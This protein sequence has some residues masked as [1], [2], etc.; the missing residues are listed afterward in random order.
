MQSTRCVHAGRGHLAAIGAHVPPIDLSSTYPM[1]EP[2]ETERA[3]DALAAGAPRSVEGV[4]ARLYN[5]TVDAYET[6]I[7]ELEGA[8]EAVAFSSGMAALTACLLAVRQTHS[9]VVG[10][11]P[12]YGGSDHLLSVGLLGLD[13]TWVSGSEV[14]DAVRPD[15]GLILLETPQNPTLG[16]VDIAATVAAAGDVPVLV[17]NT[18]A[19][20][21]L[22]QPLRHGA[23]LVLHSA[24]KALGGHGDVL[25]GL[26]AA[27]SYWA[28]RV[29]QVRAATGSVLHPL[30]AY[31]L[32]RSLQTLELRVLRAQDNAELLFIELL[33]DPRVETV[34]YPGGG[35]DPRPELLRSQL[36]GAGSVLG[37]VP[38][39]G[40][41]ASARLLEAVRIITPAVSLGGVDSLIQQP[42][43]LTH[44]Y[45]DP[46]ARDAYGAH[47]ALLRLSVGM[48][49]AEDLLA[50]LDQALEQATR[51][52]RNRPGRPDALGSAAELQAQV[53]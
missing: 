8:D 5:P 22:Q 49:D 53:R 40:A 23:A 36:A 29:R 17:D 12:V 6:A 37:F 47:P 2:A 31:L 44:R 24:T 52:S 38:V 14:A 41:P 39:G 26:V 11:R 16:Q 42:A 35:R 20:P 28:R 3:Y 18:F 51:T 27:N 15:T 48:E 21:I 1:V 10:V 25:A 7:A 4:Y 30:A 34:Y 43:A 19:T 33:R 46:S 50:D 32:H 13:V 45:V 9:H